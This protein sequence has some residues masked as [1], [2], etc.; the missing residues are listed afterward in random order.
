MSM[1]V[2]WVLLSCV[3]SKWGCKYGSFVSD[4]KTAEEEDYHKYIK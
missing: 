2:D 1:R 4:T 3:V